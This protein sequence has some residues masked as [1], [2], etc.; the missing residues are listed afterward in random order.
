MNSFRTHEIQSLESNQGKI[1]PNL[2]RLGKV[3]IDCLHVRHLLV[4][5]LGRGQLV[6]AYGSRFVTFMQVESTIVLPQVVPTSD[7]N[8]SSQVQG[9]NQWTSFHAQ[10]PLES[11]KTRNFISIH[12]GKPTKILSDIS[13]C[14]CCRHRIP[15]QIPRSRV[16]FNRRI[17][18]F[19]FD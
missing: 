17:S 6:D 14:K 12:A 1:P 2:I 19:K 7:Y 3:C 15:E 4:D 5:W 8:A 13:W 10:S 18:M 11:M 16:K 9:E